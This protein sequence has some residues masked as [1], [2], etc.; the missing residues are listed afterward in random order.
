MASPNISEMT[1]SALYD[2]SSTI[3]DNMSNNVPFFQFLKEKGNMELIDGGEFIR[4]NIEY[5]ENAG[6]QFY[7]GYELLN[8]VR[9]DVFTAVDYEWKEYSIPIMM[10]AL[11]KL[12][13]AG[14]SRIFELAA[15]R[16]KNAEK[17][18]ANRFGAAVF[19]DGTQDGGRSFIGLGGLVPNNPNSGIVGGIDSSQWAFWRNLG[20]SATA[21][22]GAAKSATNIGQYFDYMITNTTR[23]GDGIDLIVAG[24]NDY[25]KLQ[26][27][28]W[29]NTRFMP[30]NSNKVNGGIRT[31]EY[32]GIRVMNGGGVGST[33]DP[34]TSYF[35]NL[36]YIKFITASSR[37]FKPME[38]ERYSNNQNAWVKYLDWA[39]AMIT[40]NRRLQGVLYA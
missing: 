26:Q 16:M 20:I 1:T 22:F 37:N 19:L 7:S 28:L 32:Q 5:A 21:F 3:Y 35:L 30:E 31:I 39:G 2:Y 4:R 27:Y 6:G 34:D 10:S 8:P 13:N 18:I 14:D 29:T 9:S 24:A 25:A 11:E 38:G 12:Q 17:T 36:D 33:M 40:T 23:G 15:G